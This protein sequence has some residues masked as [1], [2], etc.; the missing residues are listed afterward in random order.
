MKDA[1]FVA[2]PISVNDGTSNVDVDEVQVVA[3]PAPDEGEP[4]STAR[5]DTLRSDIKHQEWLDALMLLMRAAGN[6]TRMRILYLLW[7]QGEVRVNDLATILE[8]TT[9][10]ISQQLKK[11]RQCEIV[12]TRRDAQTIYYRLN[13]DLDFV[14]CLV[15]F[16]VQG[17]YAGTAAA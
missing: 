9:P 7:R 5:M 11:L 12:K 14:Q 8:L 3:R 4:L 10:A 1:L 17:N 16:F 13:T 15:R 2:Q 6:D